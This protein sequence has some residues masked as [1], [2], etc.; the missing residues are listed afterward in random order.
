[1]CTKH[2][3]TVH[4]SYLYIYTVYVHIL[5]LVLLF[6]LNI[7]TVK[8]DSGFEIVENKCIFVHQSYILGWGLS[9]LMIFFF[10]YYIHQ[11]WLQYWY[12]VTSPTDKETLIGISVHLLFMSLWVD[13]GLVISTE[14]TGCV[15]LLWMWS[16]LSLFC[17]TIANSTW[18]TL[19]HSVAVY[20]FCHPIYLCSHCH[21]QHQ[22][23]RDTSSCIG[24]HY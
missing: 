14:P 4:E 12:A 2:W 24:S 22:G 6:H 1:M 19:K 21:V 16:A 20:P 8:K 3:N 7:S 18:G 10:T 13:W 11:T 5:F 9:L 17:K 23:L 15:G